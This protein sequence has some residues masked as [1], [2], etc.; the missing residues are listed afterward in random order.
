MPPQ[1]GPGYRS[2]DP[3]RGG[4]YGGDGYGQSGSG[5][6]NG[7]YGAPA[8]GGV[9]GAP[10][11]P[12]SG[13]V[14]G[15]PVE[16][17]VYGGSRSGGSAGAK[18][19]SGRSSGTGKA[20]GARANAA[21]GKATGASKKPKKPRSPLWTKFAISFGALLMIVSVGVYVTLQAGLHELNSA[22]TQANLLGDAPAPQLNGKAIKGPL[23]IL[24]VGVD[25]SGERTDSIIIAHIPQS[26]DRM[27]LI[28]L[29]RDT[30]VNT[31]QG[32]TN[33]INSTFN[34][35]FANLAK[36][37][38][39]NYGIRFNGGATVNFD[40]FQDIVNKLGGIDMYVDETT[41]S[42]HHGYI[43][44][45]PSKHAKPYKINPNTGVPEC[46]NRHYTFDSNPDKCT[47]PGVK[48][49]TYPKGMH[50]FNAYDALDFVRC[51]DGLVGTD[52]A[53]QRHQQQFIKA[54]MQKA[55][56]KGMS[57]PTKL[58]GFITSM[59][60]AFTFD[61]HGISLTDW[62]FTL[63]GISPQGVITIKTNG[64]KFVTAAGPS[65]GHG[66]EQG[67][68]ADSQALL[69]AVRD[70]DG[71]SDP[72]LQFISTHSDWVS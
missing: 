42:I 69:A 57:D 51:R 58:L 34:N 10:S 5:Y 29:P 28:S 19:G 33:K 67:L 21:G 61:G 15:G 48:E 71:S 32:G 62:V 37:I 17:G 7:G 66:S 55:Y 38:T 63:K 31:P 53:R 65:D 36:T 3:G 39:L 41:H 4:G 25:A 72:V 14:Y 60:R 6:G 27:Y 11:A 16:G 44:N 47:L 56:S 49:V 54:V 52:Y 9:Y 22:V 43:D 30:K 68:N 2:A 26:H 70:D 13:G 23:N 18:P 64:G 45:D 12:S 8:S 24:L 40:G 1:G 50:H 59:K 35:G 20:G 46:Y